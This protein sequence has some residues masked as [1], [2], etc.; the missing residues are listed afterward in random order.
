MSEAMLASFVSDILH[1]QPL[2]GM[3]VAS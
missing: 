2:E 3:D 1:A